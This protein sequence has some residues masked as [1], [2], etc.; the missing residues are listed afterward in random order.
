MLI[1]RVWL[2]KLTI[3]FILFLGLI[4]CKGDIYT[5]DELLGKSESSVTDKLGD[6]V[7]NNFVYLNKDTKL[8]EYQSNLYELYPDL[9]NK[10][11]V[12]KELRWIK[13]RDIVVVWFEYHG[14][15]WR[16]IDTLGWNQ[17]I[18]F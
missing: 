1:N 17:N 13:G 11:V 10:D 18:R 9:E 7:S 15:S 3:V 12:L 16:A 2:N 6:P 5:L 14:D 4:G 8:R